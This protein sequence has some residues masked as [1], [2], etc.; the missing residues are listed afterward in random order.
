[1]NPLV[2]ATTRLS[3]LSPNVS[4]KARTSD[5]A[6]PP[7]AGVYVSCEKNTVFGAISCRSISH[8]FSIELMKELTVSATC[9]TLRRVPWKA[10]LAVRV[11][12]S[13]AKG[14][15]PRFIASECR[16]T[17]NA[18]APIP[19][20]NPF[21]RRSKGNA[22]SSITLLVAAAPEAAKPPPIHS[23]KSSPVTS[24]AEIITTLSTRSLLSQSSAT[25]KAAVDD[26]QARLMVV[27]GPRIPEYC[28]N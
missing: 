19:S 11:P 4:R 3:V 6:E 14:C 10:E 22:A 21:L 12:R 7:R 16:S 28:A 20:T 25:P 23:H 8:S 13:S 27:F 24:S 5:C 18:A 17:T 1:M 9:S 2:L 26:A 15:T